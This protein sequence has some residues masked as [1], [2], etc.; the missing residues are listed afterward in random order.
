M[1][2]PRLPPLLLRL[3]V[4]LRA[5]GTAY[6]YPPTTTTRT[7]GRLAWWRRRWGE[8]SQLLKMMILAPSSHHVTA[9]YSLQLCNIMFHKQWCEF[10]LSL[11]V[12]GP[13]WLPLI[14]HLAASYWRKGNWKVSCQAAVAMAAYS[15]AQDRGNIIWPFSYHLAP[16]ST[17]FHD[18][19]Y[20]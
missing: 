7:E 6:G 20:F 2:E 14:V 17:F 3:R 9:A 11:G 4:E 12:D 10:M 8:S 16:Y 5:P 13:R 18:L 1:E 15:C 19:A